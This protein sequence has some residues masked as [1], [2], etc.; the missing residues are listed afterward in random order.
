MANCPIEIRIKLSYNF[1]GGGGE[2]SE[3]NTYKEM[4]LTM[5]RATEKAMHLLIDAQRKCEERYLQMEE[6]GN[7]E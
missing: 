3:E 7:N 4:Y 2:M 5:M 1:T 6:S